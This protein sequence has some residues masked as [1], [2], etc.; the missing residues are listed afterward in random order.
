MANP[1]T[2]VVLLA[3]TSC[4]LVQS[5][6]ADF[7]EDSR[8]F[9]WLLA[10][11]CRTSETTNDDIKAVV[12]DEKDMSYASKCILACISEH[13]GLFTEDGKFNF[14]VAFEF[15][16]AMIEDDDEKKEMRDRLIKKCKDIEDEDKCERAYKLNRCMD[17]V[18]KEFQA[19]D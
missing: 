13:F 15:F 5:E 10:E 19:E 17:E 11:D 3:I 6:K 9:I 2:V 18:D 12:D 1:I 16:D 4:R 8:T 14:D 7:E